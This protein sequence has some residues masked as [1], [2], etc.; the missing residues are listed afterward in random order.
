M[1]ADEGTHHAG[2]PVPRRLELALQLGGGGAGGV[3]LARQPLLQVAP[4]RLQAVH[5][6]MAG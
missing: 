5:L 3:P 1:R 4:L 2:H 6:R